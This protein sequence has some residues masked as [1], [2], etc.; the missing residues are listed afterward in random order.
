MAKLTSNSNV[1][2]KL[3]L[4]PAQPGCYIYKDET[5]G[6]LYVGKALSLRSRVRSYFQPSTV[7]G[8]R[9]ARL[10]T[11]VRDIEWMVVESE[12]EALVLEC[13]LIKQ[14]RPPYNVRMR[15]DKSYPYITITNEPFPRV[16]FTRKVRKDHAKYFGPYTSA[17]H[18]RDTLQ[19]LHKAFPLI[20]CGKSWSGRA[21]QRPCLYFHLGQCLGPCAGLAD[22]IEYK[23]VIDKVERFLNG[24][25][26]TLMEDLKREMHAASE[27]MDFERAAKL[28][29]QVL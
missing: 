20:P 12:V 6:V 8:P 27:S 19:L 16:L 17:F 2:D 26:E 1:L 7:H 15:D 24:R 14:Y 23:Q 28:R 5:G 10:V 25:E 4:V 11:K 21:E 13:N 18:V 22:K 29:D 3:K 9:I